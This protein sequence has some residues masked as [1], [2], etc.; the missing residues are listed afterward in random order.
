ME[1]IY[2][3]LP[4]Y[5]T[6]LCGLSRSM[7][8]KL[9]YLDLT[10]SHRSARWLPRASRDAALYWLD[11]SQ[12]EVNP[13]FSLLFVRGDG[14]G[15]RLGRWEIDLRASG[16]K[17]SLLLEPGS[18]TTALVQTISSMC[19]TNLPVKYLG[20]YHHVRRADSDGENK[21]LLARIR[22]DGGVRVSQVLDALHCVAPTV[23]ETW[24]A[25]PRSSST[26]QEMLTGSII[27]GQY[28]DI[29]ASS[30]TWITLI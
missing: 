8:E 18:A 15:H 17:T 22:N 2:T 28:L 4:A 5:Y 12:F 30:Y 26:A 24:Q 20:I 1:D 16:A 19:V 7:I 3:Y 23:L 10:Q 25:G 27:S 6:Q 21:K 13:Y 11:L 9:D 14:V 29:H